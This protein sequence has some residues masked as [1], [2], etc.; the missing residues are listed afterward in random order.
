MRTEDYNFEV[1][2]HL[3]AQHPAEHRSDSRML[4]YYRDSKKI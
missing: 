4:V 3:V 1:P 2:E